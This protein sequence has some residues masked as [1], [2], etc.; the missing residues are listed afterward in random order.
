M[1]RVRN[2]SSLRF[3]NRTSRIPLASTI[4]VFA[5]AMLA[6]ILTMNRT[7]GVY[8]EGLI[9]A[10]AARVVAGDHIHRD[11]YANYGPAQFHLLATLFSLFGSGVLTERL[12]DIIIRAGIS[13]ASWV[14]LSGICRRSVAAVGTGLISA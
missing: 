5:I 2:L 13:A 3:A 10:G 8:D 9:L 11:F 7:V 6:L 14:G 4:G 1:E 12:A